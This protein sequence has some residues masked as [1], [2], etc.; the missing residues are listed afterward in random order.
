MK[1]A[2]KKKYYQ[3]LVDA[4]THKLIWTSCVKVML[5]HNPELMKTKISANKIIYHMARYYLDGEE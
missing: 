3:L 2:S 1:Y 5:E 4:D